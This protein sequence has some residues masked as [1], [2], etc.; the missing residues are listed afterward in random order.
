MTEREKLQL[1]TGISKSSKSIVLDLYTNSYS[2]HSELAASHLLS[3][4]YDWLQ[5]LFSR[6]KE[7]L[8]Y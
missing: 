3:L 4:H 1:F 6:P 7:F 8:S 2:H 5:W